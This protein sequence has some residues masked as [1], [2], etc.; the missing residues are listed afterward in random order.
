MAFARWNR[1]APARKTFV[2]IVARS[3]IDSFAR[4]AHPALCRLRRPVASAKSER[5]GA[6]VMRLRE[7]QEMMEDVVFYALMGV[8]I[9]AYELAVAAVI[10]LG[11]KILRP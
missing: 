11:E 9:L 4:F 10:G 7:V 2:V 8:K 5:R 6:H 1:A 3:A